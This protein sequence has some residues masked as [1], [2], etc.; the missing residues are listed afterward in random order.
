MESST[1]FFM[2]L[3]NSLCI[4][5]SHY[6]SLQ[7]HRILI[8]YIMRLNTGQNGAVTILPWLPVSYLQ[9][10]FLEELPCD[11]WVTGLLGVLM[12]LY[13][14]QILNHNLKKIL[15]T[16][17]LT[18]LLTRCLANLYMHAREATASA[19]PRQFILVEYDNCQRFHTGIQ[20]YNYSLP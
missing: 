11:F 14:C 6:N 12:S 7:Y 1:C 3:L 18:A 20:K 5:A 9:E 10:S 17:I 4:P 15:V 19:C 16:Y 2:L 13:Y 8:M